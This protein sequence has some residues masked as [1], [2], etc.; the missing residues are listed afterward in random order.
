MF[1]MLCL[2]AMT[3][4]AQVAKDYAGEKFELIRQNARSEMFYVPLEVGQIR[5]EGWLHEW[6]MQAADG[7]TGHLDEYQ[8]V[9]THGWKGY[10]FEA[11]GANPED[12]TGWP[13]EQCSYWLDGAVKLAYMTGD[14]ALIEKVSKRLDMV[15]DGVLDGA[16]TFIY[17]KDKDIVKDWF[18]NWGH[19][20]MGRALI[21]YYQATHNP[22]ILQALEKVYTQF[23]MIMPPEQPNSLDELLMYMRGVTNVDAMT[24]AYLE[25]GNKTILDS[26]VAYGNRPGIQRYEDKLLAVEGRDKDGYR[27]L[28]GVTFYEGIRVAGILGLWTGDRNGLASGEHMHEWAMKYNGL[29]Y[30]MPSCEEWMSGI[31]GFHSVETCVVPASMWTYN[32]FMRLSG[33]TRWA[34]LIESV[35]FN[36]GPG[37]VARDFKTMSYYQQPNRFS[38]QLP[39][40]PPIP[41]DGDNV[42]TPYGHEVL[43]CVGSSN[44]IIPN[45]VGN[46]WQATNDGGLAYVLYG[47]CSVQ[48]RVGDTEVGLECVTDYPFA[49]SIRVKVRMSKPTAVPL[50]FHVPEWCRDMQVRVNGRKFKVADGVSSVRLNLT[51]NDGDEILL[52]M[53]MTAEV[54]EGKEVAYPRDGYFTGDQSEGRNK[55]VDDAEGGMPYQYVKHGPLLYSLPLKDIDENHVAPGQKYNYALNIKDIKKDIRV[56][57][58]TMPSG[59]RWDP[60]SSPVTLTVKAREF[61]WNPTQAQP[62]PKE[63]VTGDADT[64]I[65]LIPYN[66]TKFR[67]TMFPVAE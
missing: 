11:R 36:A 52:T 57:R 38:E 17:W 60:E 30:G 26:L 37:P 66:L 56:K 19:G 65:Q 59:W 23:Y 15:V 58:S 1:S 7:I 25:S 61:D 2:S 9:Y 29:P 46:M 27:S 28:H 50:Y 13:I 35:F 47:P 16:D 31:G 20:I 64:R 63:K 49:E 54:T 43:C 32:W 6:A 41:G 12:G 33:D 44:W 53:P 18:N 51:W 5:P 67:L 10:G 4:Q 39:T 62:M 8:P 21:D 48:T 45:Y 42:F 3:L 40:R 55:L 22:R 24:E 14:K 34:D